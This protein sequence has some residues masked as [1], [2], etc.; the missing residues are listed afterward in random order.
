MVIIYFK[1]CSFGMNEKFHICRNYSLWFCWQLWLSES[2]VVNRVVII[3]HQISQE[4]RHQVLVLYPSHQLIICRRRNLAEEV[5]NLVVAVQVHK[6]A[7]VQVLNMEAVAP[8]KEV[9]PHQAVAVVD[10]ALNQH[11]PIQKAL[12][13]IAT[14]PPEDSDTAV[15]TENFHVNES[16]NQKI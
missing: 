10:T 14:K 6:L 9:L 11:Q 8:H 7:A 13:A 4:L 12:T 3:C 15:A 16:M 2:S 1:L 5:R